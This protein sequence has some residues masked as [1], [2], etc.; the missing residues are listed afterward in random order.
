MRSLFSLLPVLLFSASC[1]S[2]FTDGTPCG[3]T[4]RVT[5]QAVLPDTGLGARGTAGI[6]FYESEPGRSLDET[7]LFVWTFPHD[8][9]VRFAD[10]APHVRVVTDEG[11]VLLDLD[12]SLAYQGSWYVR[13][14]VPA[15]SMRQAI[16]N[17]FQSGK[18]TVEFSSTVPARVT[19][20][21]PSVEFAGRDPVLL[22]K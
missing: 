14:P 16:V 8:S 1:R 17:A 13:Q 4:R 21:R 6:T 7:S 20:V 5:A 3:G 19:R 18:V 22:C 15:E 11:L 10:S 2:L 9:T 12:S